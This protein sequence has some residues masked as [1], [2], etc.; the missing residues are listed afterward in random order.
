MDKK[1]KKMIAPIIIVSIIAV[2]YIGIGVYFAYMA[3]VPMI[4]KI[5][6]L[7]IPAALAG[8]AI[9][10]LVQRIKEIRKGE[11]DDISKY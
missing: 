9:T 8:V 10:V 3:G 7:I 2:Y 11:D 6:A 5:L 1:K 4:A